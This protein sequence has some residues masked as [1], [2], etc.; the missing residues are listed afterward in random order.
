MS[1][2]QKHHWQTPRRDFDDPSIMTIY[3]WGIVV[4]TMG[5]LVV[6]MYSLEMALR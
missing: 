6:Y 1:I 4:V 2:A 3:L 5:T